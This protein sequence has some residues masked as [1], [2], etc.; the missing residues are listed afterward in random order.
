[1]ARIGKGKQIV[2]LKKRLLTSGDYRLYLD[3]Y[4][5]GNRHIETLDL[6]LSGKTDQAAKAQNRNNLRMA[7]I[8]RSNKELDIVTG[9]HGLIPDFK[10]KTSLIAYFKQQMEKRKDGIENYGNWQSALK[11]LEAY[12]QRSILL[13]DINEDWLDGWIEYLTK[14]AKKKDGEPL[15]QNSIVSYY[16]KVAACLKQALKDRL[17]I[18]NPATNVKRP[19]EKE[20]KREVLTVD[21]IKKLIDTPCEDVD[22]KRAFLFSC[23]TGLRWSDV[24]KLQWSEI[25][26]DQIQFR[27]QKTGSFEYMP[28]HPTAKKLLGE[29]KEGTQRIFNIVYHKWNNEKITNWIKKA[30]ITKKITFHNARHTYATLLLTNGADLYTVQKL[31]GHANISTT[32]VYAKVVD[33]K[34]L[35]AVNALPVVELS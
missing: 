16:N 1:M 8:I 28:L 27:Q 26:N 22:I 33:E 18:F 17:I 14:E 4:Y 23:F 5:K 31:L 34:K 11:H 30:G 2:K 29:P 32:A 7:E 21:E 24:E 35:K 12:E 19:A 9:K 20:V 6:F 25:Q 15:S 3:I 13:S 10:K